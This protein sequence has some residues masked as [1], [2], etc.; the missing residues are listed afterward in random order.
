MSYIRTSHAFA[1][2]LKDAQQAHI[3]AQYQIAGKVD[4]DELM[5]AATANVLGQRTSMYRETATRAQWRGLINA[6]VGLPDVIL[7]VTFLKDCGTTRTMLCQPYAV[8]SDATKRYATVWDVEIG[9][10]RRINLD[11]VVKLTVETHSVDA[12]YPEKYQM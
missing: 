7:A 3:E 4:A 2:T 9:G 12:Q 10:F 5:A 8:D 6:C 1:V 11:A